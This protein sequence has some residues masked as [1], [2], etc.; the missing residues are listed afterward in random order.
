MVLA[1]IRGQ[2]LGVVPPSG[3]SAMVRTVHGMGLDGPRPC[4][5]GGSPLPDGPRSRARRSAHAE[6]RRTIYLAS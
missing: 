2:T 3:V 4:Y 6:G 5:M 1:S